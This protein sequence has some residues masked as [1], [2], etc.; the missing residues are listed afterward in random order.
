MDAISI[1]VYSLLQTLEPNIYFNK[2]QIWWR[3][4]VQCVTHELVS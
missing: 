1:C 4:T 3:D 2:I